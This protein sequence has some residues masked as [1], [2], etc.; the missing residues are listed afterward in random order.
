VAR[1]EPDPDTSGT[2]VDHLL[3]LYGAPRRAYHD[4]AHLRAVLD[5]LATIA[6]APDDH[7][8]DTGAVELAGWFHDAVLE[9]LAHDNEARSADL[10]AARLPA[11]GV[12]A[13]VVEE[14]VR[15]VRL[16]ETHQVTFGDRNAAALMDADLAVLG[17]SPV[18]YERYRAA[19]RREYAAV[20]DAEFQPARAAVL[21]GLLEHALFHTATVGTRED[22]AR[23]NVERELGELER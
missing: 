22:Q 9:P 23:A 3:R 14:V 6:S 1:W 17:G 19:V 7:C 12:S 21:R 8:D 16:T 5:T 15:L 4:V 11:L 2:L 10:A 18:E 20:G 13:P